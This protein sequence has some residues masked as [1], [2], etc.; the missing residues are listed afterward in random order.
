MRST[1]TTW[2]SRSGTAALK[3][4]RSAP[5]LKDADI[6]DLLTYLHDK[7]CY[8][9]TNPP[10]NP[11]YRATAQNSPAV[12]LRGNLRGGPRGS[13]DAAGGE[14]LEGIA[15]QLIAPNGIRTTV[16]SDQDGRYEF[17]QLS[18]G[19]YTLRIAKPLEFLPY[20]RDAVK[21][22]EARDVR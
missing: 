16:S 5:S 20:R 3:C 11:W 15:V 17:P 2:Q 18:S 7:C 19:S 6:A 8:E 22:D 1:T 14:A 13:V 12:P 21:V 9:E 10:V 4:R